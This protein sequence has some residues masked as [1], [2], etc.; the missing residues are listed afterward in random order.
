MVGVQSG[1]NA[2]LVLSEEGILD[3]DF[4][5]DGTFSTPIAPMVWEQIW[6]RGRWRLLHFVLVRMLLMLLLLV[7]LVVLSIVVG[8]VVIVVAVAADLL[9]V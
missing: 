3:V 4:R 9:L 2:D 8:V 5:H 1:E 7:L 6:P